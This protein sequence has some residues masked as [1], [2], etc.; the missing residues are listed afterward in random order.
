MSLLIFMLQTL[1]LAV[2][3]ADVRPEG[4]HDRV[5]IT[6][7]AVSGPDRFF[8]SKRGT[9]TLWRRPALGREMV[10]AETG[11]SVLESAAELILVDRPGAIA[12]H[13]RLEGGNDPRMLLLSNGI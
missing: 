8:I 13:C 3:G 10:D 4:C 2:C 9:K 5:T 7:S 12:G 11:I 1:I 6:A